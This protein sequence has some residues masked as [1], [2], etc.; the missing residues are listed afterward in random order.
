MLWLPQVTLSETSVTRVIW[1][2]K[3]WT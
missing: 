1:T 3:L 2:P